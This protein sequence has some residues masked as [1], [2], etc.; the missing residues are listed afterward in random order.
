MGKDEYYPPP[1][2][3]YNPPK[4]PAQA[5]GGYPQDQR[6]PPPP[7]PQG[8]YPPQQGYPQQYPPQ[9]TSPDPSS[10]TPLPFP[11]RGNCGIYADCRGILR[12]T[13]TGIYP[14]T[15]SKRFSGW[16]HLLW[17]VLPTVLVL[18]SF[19]VWFGWELIVD[20]RRLHVAVASIVYFRQRMILLN[21]STY[22]DVRWISEV[23]CC[24]WDGVWIAFGDTLWRI[25]EQF[26]F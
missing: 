24:G 2:Q 3:G 7:P 13:S 6:G 1:Q 18:D 21:W 22:K 26:V 8:Y 25:R 23:L 15:T 16:W 17:N 20:V 5:Y 14:T 9:R 10:L 4:Q 19:H 12:T 11:D